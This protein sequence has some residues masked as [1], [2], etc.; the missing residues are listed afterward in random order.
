M[1]FPLPKQDG[2]T[3]YSKSG[4]K[5]CIKVKE[6]FKTKQIFFKEI[7]CDEI[8]IDSKIEFLEFIATLTS[9]NVTKFPIVFNGKNYIGSYDETRNYINNISNIDICF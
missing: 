7:D 3:I 2:I 9:V 5:N 8:L 4:C 6:L 1:E